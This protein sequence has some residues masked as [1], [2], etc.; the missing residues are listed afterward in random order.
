MKIKDNLLNDERFTNGGWWIHQ[1][2]Y[3]PDNDSEIDPVE[4]Q[5]EKEVKGEKEEYTAGALPVN[6]EIFN[7]DGDLISYPL[8]ISKARE[9]Y[10]DEV[11][12][13]IQV[14]DITDVSIEALASMIGVSVKSF[15]QLTYNNHKMG[16]LRH[17]HRSEAQ[18]R[19][20]EK[21]RIA[22]A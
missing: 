11:M 1:G 16:I 20:H 7:A 22:R 8:Y 9:Q 21:R 2:E 14:N 3:Y 13:Y 19:V 4:K 18:K 5:Q 10:I 15:K 12:R 6:I 17:I